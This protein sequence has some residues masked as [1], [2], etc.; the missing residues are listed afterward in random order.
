MI[1]ESSPMWMEM[2]LSESRNENDS[3]L[4]TIWFEALESLRRA[5]G[6]ETFSMRACPLSGWMFR[7]WFYLFL[8]PSGRLMLFF[9]RIRVTASSCFFIQ[10]LSG[11]NPF[12][13]QEHLTFIF[14]F[15]SFVLV[16]YWSWGLIKMMRFLLWLWSIQLSLFVILISLY[17]CIL[18]SSNKHILVLG[19]YDDPHL[20][21]LVMLVYERLNECIEGWNFPIWNCD[22]PSMECG[23]KD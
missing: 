22:I 12:P 21:K 11:W 16:L 9:S 10:E 7:S 19:R 3:L 2:L 17:I 15:F 13:Q 6:F 20:D 5:Q 23:K 18:G 8:V 14:P 4:P 1:W